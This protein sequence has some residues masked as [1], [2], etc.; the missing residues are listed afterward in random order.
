MIITISKLRVQTD[1]GELTDDIIQSRL[2]AIEQVIRKYTNNNFQNR[3]VRFVSSSSGDKLMGTSL[4]IR[5]GDTIQI[6]QS[7]VNDGLYVVK[8]VTEDSLTVDRELFDFPSNMV[9]KIEYPQD[10]I[11]CALDLFEWKKNFG[12]KIG[13]KSESETLSRHSESVTYEDSATLF[14][15]YPVGILKGLSLHK[16]ARC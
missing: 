14:M 16:K 13:I 7:M 1:C 10:V 3:N 5:K 4:F 11:Q 15:G 9:T 6:S 8:E 12:A 2:D